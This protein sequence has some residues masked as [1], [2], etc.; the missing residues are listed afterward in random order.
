MAKTGPKKKAKHLKI[1]AG[2]VRKDRDGATPDVEEAPL[3]PDPPPHLPELAAGFWRW[4][5]PLLASRGI[6]TESNRPQVEEAA[7]LYHRARTA[8]AVLAKDGATF[9][10]EKTGN[11]KR[12]PMAVESL[13][14][15]KEMRLALSEIGLTDIQAKPKG[16]ANP[17]G[18]FVKLVS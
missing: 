7:M 4:V 10:C 9:V 1:G 3:S 11:P 17:F 6:G 15:W 18:A 8:D 2:T 14:C 12:H 16:E 13:Q 5:V